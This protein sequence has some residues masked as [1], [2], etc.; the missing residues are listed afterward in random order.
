MD[1]NKFIN[2]SGFIDGIK[3]NREAAVDKEIIEQ[4]MPI[5][6]CVNDTSVNDSIVKE[7]NKF[8]VIATHSDV[9]I[10]YRIYL[11]SEMSAAI[12]TWIY[13]YQKPIL[14]H[15]NDWSDPVGKVIEA[16]YFTAAELETIKD[17][18]GNEKIPWPENA[19]GATLLKVV[20]TDQDMY[21]KVRNGVFNTVSVGMYPDKHT[22]SICGKDFADEERCPR[23]E[24]RRV[25]KE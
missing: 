14:K 10:N 1:F 9:E 8:W 7:E 12:D 2:N 18:V 20:V 17:M 19:T 11:Q 21:E 24:E 25:G 16:I 3:R 15:H 5:V 6:A 22:C 13:P 23:S 4:T